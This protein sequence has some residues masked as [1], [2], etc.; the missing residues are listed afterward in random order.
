MKQQKCLNCGGVFFADRERKFCSHRCN[1][2]YLQR[3]YRAGIV[4][5]SPN[6]CLMNE[7][8]I[9]KKRNCENCGWNPKVARKRKEDILERL[10][11]GTN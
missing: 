1:K 8:V 2:T 7:G 5:R 3:N 11:N 10:R 4:T 9:C 6:E